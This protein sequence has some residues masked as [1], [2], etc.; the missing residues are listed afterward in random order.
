MSQRV[1]KRR[2][3]TEHYQRQK[4]HSSIN[5]ACLSVREFAGS[6]E[7]TAENVCNQVEVWLEDKLEVTSNDL[8]VAAARFLQHYNPAAAKLYINYMDIN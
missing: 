2:K 3:H 4:L 5:A 8:R 6:A 7:I 1:V